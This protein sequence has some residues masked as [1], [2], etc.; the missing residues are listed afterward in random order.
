MNNRQRLRA[1]L[2]GEAVDRPPIWLRS[3]FDFTRPP[4]EADDPFLGWQAEPRYRDLYEFAKPHCAMRL[5]WEPTDHF[6]TPAG[7]APS[8][9]HRE[10][11]RDDESGTEQEDRVDTPRGPL[12]SRRERR[13][14]CSSWWVTKPLAAD[15]EELEAILA[16]SWE[17]GPLAL[18]D[19]ERADRRVGDLGLPCLALRSPL[20]SL[21]AAMDFQ[22]FLLL[23]GTER[24]FIHEALETVTS[25]FERLLDATFANG[26]LGTMANIGGSE[27]C[28]PPMLPADWYDDLIAPYDGRL[29]KKLKEKGVIAVNC[30]C[31]GKVRYALPR[32]VEMG[33]DA[34]DPVE[35]PPAG[36]VTIAEAAKLTGGRL[37]L[38]G[39][40]E[41]DELETAETDHIRRRIRE[42]LDVGSRRIIV[43]ASAG[44]ISRL[45][46][47]L[48]NNYRALIETVLDG[49]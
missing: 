49:Q 22:D 9:F 42:I 14:G 37:T 39:N 47:R 11:I 3:G 38:A 5:F 15:R 7:V 6:N 29:V 33:F 23:A 13:P 31:H 46:E 27:Q 40:L 21:S 32:M 28:T 10:T 30:H 35:P 16:T 45:S 20:R 1:A 18:E 36:D 17:I 8:R 12:V 41:F 2:L 48:D 19:F 25:R 4:A 43:S 34:T 26:A 44:P 24:E